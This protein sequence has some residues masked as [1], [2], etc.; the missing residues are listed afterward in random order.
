MDLLSAFESGME[1]VLGL[2]FEMDIVDFPL[3]KAFIRRDINAMERQ[4]NRVSEVNS[5]P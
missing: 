2:G 5:G 3:G 1:M 4:R